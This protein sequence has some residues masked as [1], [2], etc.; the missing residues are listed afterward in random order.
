MSLES[1]ERGE[2]GARHPAL[3]SS[4][5]LLLDALMRGRLDSGE[6][7]S[8]SKKARA[9]QEAQNEL[10]D[11][12]LEIEEAPDEWKAP[13]RESRAAQLATR[14]SFIINVGLCGIKF[15]A[16]ALSGSLVVL[17]SA[18][19]STLDLFSGAVMYFQAAASARED[20]PAMRAKYPTGLSRLEPVAVLIFAVLMASLSLQILVESTTALVEGL[21]KTPKRPNATPL[22]IAIMVVVIVVKFFLC[23]WCRRIADRGGPG[24]GVVEAL[25]DDHRNDVVSNT[26]GLGAMMAAAL[27]PGACWTADP[28][29]AMLISC[30]L[31]ATWAT[32]AREQAV[33]LV[34]VAPPP[35]FHA[36]VTFLAL[37]ASPRLLG[38]DTLVVYSAGAT[39]YNVELD[40]ILPPEMPHREAHDVGQ[41]LQD[42]LEAD[43]EVSRA[44]VHLDWEASHDV[45]HGGRPSLAKRPR[46][47]SVD[48]AAPLLVKKGT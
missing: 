2:I 27:G 48:A 32:T 37:K 46:T 12:L 35:A 21:T 30:V 15:L 17:A 13:E 9:Y 43:E 4:N 28:I 26:W 29:G 40:I 19:D 1:V 33:R 10:V 44:F 25:A 23:I 47:P 16:Y 20:R 42:R 8:K 31:I 39:T 7:A 3:S 38:I 36:R 14:L 34:G 5:P 6:L 45:E 22:V 11:A 41:A 24:A 18:V